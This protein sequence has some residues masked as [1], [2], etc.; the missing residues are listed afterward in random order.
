MSG[1]R[2]KIALMAAKEIVELELD[3]AE[4]T[5]TL[6]EVLQEMEE[7]RVRV[8]IHR[9][10]IDGVALCR[11]CAT[12][13][14]KQPDAKWS[15]LVCANC[16]AF[17]EHASARLEMPSLAPFKVSQAGDDDMAD[18][19]SCFSPDEGPLAEVIAWHD[20]PSSLDDWR[21]AVSSHLAASQGMQSWPDVPCTLWQ[22]RARKY[23][24]YCAR[25]FLEC[26]FHFVPEFVL[27]FPFL[28][29]TS[30]YMQALTTSDGG[31]AHV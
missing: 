31:D 13:P 8:N 6:A 28:L 16:S 12:F 24:D 11:S 30:F 7:H 4:S 20:N 23:P 18:W 29:D 26:L 17:N 1:G 25:W 19:L 3:L 14:I 9:A 21:R 5:S 27:E 15:Y 10:L 2:D 22:R